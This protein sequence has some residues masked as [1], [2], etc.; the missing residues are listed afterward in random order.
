MPIRVLDN[1]FV[2][3]IDHMGDDK[4]IVESARI[5]FKGE[6]GDPARDA[7]LIN[8]LLTHG[9]TS[10]LEQV[11]FSFHIKLPIFVMRQLVRHRTAR[12][13]EVSARYTRLC[14]DFYLPS[15]DRFRT[16]GKANKQGSDEPLSHG[17]AVEMQSAMRVICKEAYEMYQNLLE[18]GLA[19]ETARII[20]PT[21]IYTEVIWQMDLNNIL[22]FLDQRLHP[23]AQ[24]EIQQY[25]RAIKDLI[26]PIVPITLKCWGEMKKPTE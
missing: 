17:R 26:D 8:Y 1:G 10:P 13:N 11:V 18:G 23:H 2:S 24:W 14:D 20:L 21:N 15:L 5:S 9:H 16:Q 3:L 4:R 19:R 12:L 7:K 25:A 6:S 22:K